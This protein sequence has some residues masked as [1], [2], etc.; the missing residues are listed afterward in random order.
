M[1]PTPL[2]RRALLRQTTRLAIGV[3][4]LWA[5][6]IRATTWMSPD[7]AMR[8]LMPGAD[9]FVPVH[10]VLSTDQKSQIAQWTDTRVP[11]SFAPKVWSA[12]AHGQGLGWVLLDRV[13]GKFDWI[14][15]AVAF[16]IQGIALGLEVLAYRESH[17]GEVRQARWRQQFVGRKGPQAMRWGEDIRNISGSTLSCQHV[18]QGVQRLSALLRLLP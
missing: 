16:D 4:A 18:T 3:S 12:L 10:W 17:G 15:Y 7:Q 6:P 1:R 2:H 9:D 13:I 5:L 11:P 8:V 14:D